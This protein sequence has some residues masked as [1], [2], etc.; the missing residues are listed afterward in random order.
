MTIGVTSAVWVGAAILARY[1]YLRS[2]ITTAWAARYGAFL[3]SVLGAF[4][5][6]V[7]AVL[8]LG[9]AQFVNRMFPD[10][11]GASITPAERRSAGRGPG[12]GR[13]R[14]GRVALVR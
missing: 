1:F 8:L 11:P 2:F 13:R 10:Q 9:A 7:G 5:L 3:I 14:A 12:R 6:L 4:G